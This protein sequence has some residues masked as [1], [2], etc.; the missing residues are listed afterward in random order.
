MSGV[1]YPE[2]HFTDDHEIIRIERDLSRQG[3]LHTVGAWVEEDLDIR[4]RPVFYIHRIALVQVFGSNLHALAVYNLC[5]VVVSSWLLFA[6]AR[7]IGLPFWASAVLPP[8]TFIG[9]Q[10]EIWWRLGVNETLAMS[11]FSAGVYF[12]A[13]GVFDERRRRMKTSVAI[14]LFVTA[15]LTK[16]SFILL[17]PAVALLNLWIYQHR[18][19]KGLWDAI[20]SN[21]ASLTALTATTLI[22]IYIILTIVGTNRIG[23][24][25]V[26]R[27]GM[28]LRSLYVTFKQF[29]RPEYSRIL[30]WLACITALL[31]AG[32][33]VHIRRMN[34]SMSRC[35]SPQDTLKACIGRHRKRILY[36][37]YFVLIEAAILLPQL[38]L[39]AKSGVM[40]RYL[41]PGV[42]AFSVLIS[43]IL[44][45]WKDLA[46]RT[47]LRRAASLTGLLLVSYGLYVGAKPMYLNAVAYTNEGAYTHEF[48]SEIV[49]NTSTDDAVLVVLEPADHFEWGYS[50]YHYLTDKE[51]YRNLVFYPIT[52]DATLDSEFGS[53]LANG[54]LGMFD[55]PVVLEDLEN[56]SAVHTCAIFPGMED[57]FLQRSRSW[58][59]ADDF[60][61]FANDLFVVY[62]RH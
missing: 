48:L 6:A 54:F 11:C 1:L 20:K 50:L 55:S 47:S 15:S 43:C 29:Y 12:M 27:G 23:Y 49:N 28:S 25:G 36:F 31:I 3:Y 18:S 60:E 38:I 4:F 46:R 22:D 8:L 32:R 35:I 41:I 34:D 10:G 7:T 5:F 51:E 62:T 45:L 61:R 52:L 58:F 13:R 30:P 39:H 19:A 21:A 44:S 42:L 16:E 17:L 9:I 40:T 26:E 53:G 2:Y 37:S 56:R 14:A 59:T 24:A 33:V 57:E